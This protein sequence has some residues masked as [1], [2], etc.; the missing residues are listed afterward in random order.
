M[1]P[2]V[3]MTDNPADRAPDNQDVIDVY[4]RL[5]LKPGI[6]AGPTIGVIS[7]PVCNP[8]VDR[9]TVRGFRT[10]I[11]LQGCMRLKIY[12]ILPAILFFMSAIA[13]AEASP[14]FVG[15]DVCAEC[16]PEQLA[17]WSGSHHDLAMQVA[18]EETVLGDFDNA[19]LTHYGVTSSFFRKDG[20]FMVRTEGADGKL[21]DFPISYTFGLEPLQQYLI[22]FPGG[23]LQ[24]L[25]LAWDARPKARGGQRWFH[26]YPDEKIAPDDE[27]HWTQPGQNWN[28]MCAECHSTNLDKNYDP[29]TRAFSTSWSEI[30]VSCEACHGPGSE[31]VAWAG[32]KPG[33]EKPESGMGLAILL[34][35]RERVEWKLD[36]ETGNAVRSR[37][38]ESDREIGMCARCHSRRSPITGT[39]VHG[40]PLLDHYLPRR[41]DEGMYFADGQIDDEV[42]VYGSFIQSKMF[43]AGVTCSDCHEPHSLQLRAPGNGVCL[44]CHAATKYDQASHH[45]HEP[46]SAGASC[47]ECH[48]PARN[49]M[50]VDPRHDHS[51]RIPRPDLSVSLG[52]PSACNNCHQDKSPEWAAGQVRSW[53]G[54]APAGFQ[55]YAQALHDARHEQPDSGDA[56]AALI[57]DMETPAIARATALAQIGP[58]LGAATID[59]LTLGL[60]DADPQVRAA[61][62]AVLEYVPAEIRVRLAFPVLEDPVRAVRI[63]AARLLA[64]IP[65]GEL[66]EDQRSLLDK[67]LREY[68]AAQQAMAER[69]E[70]Q[71]SLGNLHAALGEAQQAAVAYETAID[72]NP[73]YIPGYVNLA[74]LY[75]AQGKET[76]AENILRLAARVSPGNADVHHALGLSLVRQQRTKEAIGEL[77]LASTLN[78]DN[79]RYIYVYAVALNSTG[80]PEEALMTLQGAH[81]RHPGNRDILSALVAFHRDAGNQAAARTYAEKLRSITR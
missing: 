71:T 3:Q 74:D 43:H 36:P 7:D 34:D 23:R 52:T 72:L 56:L 16:H 13:G 25:S 81:T 21:Q 18:S 22:E 17:Q 42:Y 65:V 29:V 19:S 50:V 53:Y 38:R 66:A 31:H 39:Y 73:E 35:E 48:M 1:K 55:S 30:D 78:P 14:Q 63:E 69:P 58:Y 46:G 24:A 67:V 40:E 49:Y 41:L 54:H 15:R 26:L 75:R 76:D 64:S 77:R 9:V 8:G 45:F 2:V 12:F 62:V 33:R 60:S 70:A 6:Q 5:Q 57:R 32:R 68:V 79:A 28:S 61:A 4:H 20:Q 37:V 51:M 11:A 27:L 44:Q 10:R 80:E 59:V 47:A